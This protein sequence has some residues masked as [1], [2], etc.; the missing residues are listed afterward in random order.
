[1]KKPLIAAMLL[2]S[3]CVKAQVK[4]GNNPSTINSNSLLELESTNKGFLPPRV[5]LNS[6]SSVAPLTGTVPAGM[7]VYS[8]DGSLTD[9]FYYWSGTEWKGVGS[10]KSN[11][12]SKTA[13]ATLAK[14][15]NFVLASNDVT[16][17]LPVVTASDNGMEITVKN[18][19]S[20]TDLVIVAANGS[21]TID[22]QPES[23]LTRH[24]TQT[25]I[26]T[27]GNWVIKEAVKFQP[28]I[29]T[30]NMRGSWTTLQ[31]V[32]DYL[33]AHMDGPVVVRLSDATY[34]IDE[35]ID[36]NLPF[37]LT[38]QGATYGSAS[39]I[40]GAGMSGK[41]LFRCVSESY[42]KML[43]FDATAQ[44]TYGT[45][46]GEDAIRLVGS[47]TYHEIKDCTFDRFYNTIL[48]SSDAELWLFECDI[49]N[50][51]C[52]GV[53]MHSAVP[54]AKIRVSETDFINCRR[55]FN[56][57]KGNQ[58][59]IS[60]LAG[61]Y[62][63]ENATDSG[64]IYNAANFTSMETI[65][66]YS[67]SWNHIGKFI[68]GFDFTR[69]DSRDANAVIE[70]NVGVGDKN[71]HCNIN[72]LNGSAITTVGTGGTWYKANWTNTSS[73]TC[74]W[75]IGNNRIT[76]QPTGKRNGWFIITGNLSI[77][78]AN[79][80]VSLGIVKNGNTSVRYGETTLRLTTGSQPFQFSTVVYVSDISPGDY[81]EVFCTSSSSGDLVTFQDVQWFANTQ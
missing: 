14:S 78:S 63:N 49:S 74:K 77:N 46:A 66:I 26:A 21:A 62:L 18:I 79:K 19:G 59:T 34:E 73:T 68:E 12:V 20:H 75:T 39:I 56:M 15:E 47:G 51:Q 54:G 11:V 40:P 64:I 6:V 9:G 76:Y 48:D 32:I 5:A 31:E 7:L 10:N 50:A 67:N 41:P 70:K 8:A 33:Q 1:M 25:F 45:G 35:T 80:T 13:D 3:V 57:D 42:F 52:N 36:I 61:T 55:G 44:P 38:I 23:F 27:G 60:L 37:P 22:E 30:V 29:L 65:F 72:L 17:T 43:V 58:A 16:I 71:P 53:L 69:T 4:I 24:M 28:S 2:L 81:F